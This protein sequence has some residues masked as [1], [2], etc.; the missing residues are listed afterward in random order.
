MTKTVTVSQTDVDAAKLW[1]KMDRR[2]GRK[3]PLAVLRIAQAS[4]P[5]ASGNGGPTASL[6]AD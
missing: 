1:I 4:Q 3:T 5:Q 6:H 2:L